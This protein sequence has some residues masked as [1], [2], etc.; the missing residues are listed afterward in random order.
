MSTFLVT[1]MGRSGTK[2]LTNLLNRS[3]S[4]TVRH[5]PGG[6]ADFGRPA[7]AI[8]ARFS[9]ACKYGE[10]N[11]VIRHQAPDL[12]V[13]VKAVLLRDPRDVWL[14]MANRRDRRDWNATLDEYERTAA[15]LQRLVLAGAF[16]IDFHA[17]THRVTAVQDVAA[18]LGIEDLP[19]IP[20]IAVK[21]K[22]NATGHKRHSLM[23][24]FPHSICA[25]VDRL[26]QVLDE[27][28]GR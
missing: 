26:V 16:V 15:T 3:P 28:K 20:Q 5:E 10:V 25:R 11:S 7:S 13:D 24:E 4:W 21:R 6:L 8:Q 27:L 2:F 18:R 1:G 12:E 22:E 23:S 19:R 17:I 9:G 14:S